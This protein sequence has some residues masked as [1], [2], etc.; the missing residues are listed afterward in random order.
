MIRV[1]NLIGQWSQQPFGEHD[2]DNKRLALQ[3]K[4]L[5]G[6]WL[7]KKDV[8]ITIPLAIVAGVLVVV[9]SNTSTTFVALYVLALIGLTTAAVIR[10]IRRFI[11]AIVVTD[12]ALGMD[13]AFFYRE[14]QGGAGGLELT[15][16]TL[17]LVPYWLMWLA[18]SRRNG[19]KGRRPGPPGLALSVPTVG[20]ILASVIS[21]LAAKDLQYSYFALARLFQ[22]LLLYA[23]I[24]HNIQDEDDLR[25]Y[26]NV[27]M[28][29]LLA[30]SLLIIFQFTTKTNIDK[31]IGLGSSSMEG[32]EGEVE[33]WRAAG[34]LGSPTDA[35]AYLLPNLL[36]I[37]GVLL[38]RPTTFQKYLGIAAMVSGLWA[39]IGTQ[40]RAGL[41]TITSMSSLLALLALYRGYVKIRTVF[42]LALV[43]LVIALSFYDVIFYRLITDDNKSAEDRVPIMRVAENMIRANPVIGVGANNY[44]E[45]MGDYP[46]VSKLKDFFYVV[47]NRYLFVWAETGTIGFVCLLWFVAVWLRNAYYA[48]SLNDRSL[49][50]IALGSLV[51]VF[52]SLINWNVEALSGRQE[53]QGIWMLTALAAA[54]YGL[55][56]QKRQ[57]LA[58]ENTSPATNHDRSLR[59]SE[60]IWPTKTRT[61]K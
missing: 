55:A 41:S 50:P 12:L 38:S 20:V 32:V 51:G 36:L 28:V 2:G 23:Y 25:F 27:L 16:T 26:L 56:W 29:V 6:Q 31:F 40:S 33:G 45:V 14:H 5:I 61:H 42:I 18:E 24:V 49:S 17:V 21:M 39:L 37:L 34:T 57:S 10:N 52:A 1:K 3:A 59:L 9:S 58:E 53:E 46:G 35:A 22:F 15:L 19:A 13:I 47:H 30:E 8:L 48:Y 7:R 11:M 60:F 54:L 44:A 4:N 43:A